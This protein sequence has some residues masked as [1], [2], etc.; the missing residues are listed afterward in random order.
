MFGY[1]VFQVKYVHEIW[2]CK[3]QQ[4]QWYESPLIC[5]LSYQICIQ[6]IWTS[7]HEGL[8][9]FYGLEVWRHSKGIRTL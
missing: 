8:V 4:S 7:W 3:T 5:T 2:H 6:G 1:L 9:Q